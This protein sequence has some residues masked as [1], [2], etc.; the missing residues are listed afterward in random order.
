MALE[1]PLSAKASV[2]R[3]G[4]LQETILEGILQIEF[5]KTCVLG[6]Y[7]SCIGDIINRKKV[8]ELFIV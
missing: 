1:A 6:S 8:I 7:I 4:G 2:N 5:I 3:E